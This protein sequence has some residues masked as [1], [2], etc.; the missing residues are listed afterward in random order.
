MMA[1]ADNPAF[2]L[3]IRQAALVQMK[4]AVKKYWDSTAFTI[5]VADK[6]QIANTLIDA[7]IRVSQIQLLLRIY[8]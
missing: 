5:S 3:P 4:I 6:N 7:I 2:E 1:I 8:K